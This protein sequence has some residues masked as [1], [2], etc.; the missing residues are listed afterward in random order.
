MKQK[1]MVSLEYVL[2][3]S[4]A[5]SV[6]F[7]ISATIVSLY[8]KNITAIDNQRLKNTCKEI[9]QTIELFEL[10][11]LAKKEIEANNLSVWVFEKKNNETTLKNKNKECKI[12]TSLNL[13]TPTTIS[14]KYTF[15][16]LKQN[17]D[18]N[19]S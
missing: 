15:V 11:P 16:I 6:L 12:N 18:L 2:I 5:L 3:F 13:K 19:I 17:N 7:L 8:D 14:E 4:G 1:G 9:N 10:M